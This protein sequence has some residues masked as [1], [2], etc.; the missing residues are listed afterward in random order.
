MTPHDVICELDHCVR[1]GKD[2]RVEFDDNTDDYARAATAVRAHALKK[3]YHKTYEFWYDGVNYAGVDILKARPIRSDNPPRRGT[4]WMSEV[5]V[6][7]E[8]I[9]SPPPPSP[10]VCCVCLSNPPE[11]LVLP[12]GHSVACKDCS[13]QLETTANARLCVVC[14]QPISEILVDQA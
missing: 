10:D 5:W 1:A 12:C 6:F 14:R 11:T 9:P 2:L 8:P 4:C 3:G 7:D 13:R